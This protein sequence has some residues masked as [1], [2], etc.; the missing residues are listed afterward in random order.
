MSG[1]ATDVAFL[2]RALKMP[3]PGEVPGSL[4]TRLGTRA[5]T[6]RSS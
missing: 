2:T 1:A 5:G 4:A 3:A 6:T